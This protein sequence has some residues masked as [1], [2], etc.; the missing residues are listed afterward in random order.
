[1]SRAGDGGVSIDIVL[2]V[3]GADIARAAYY[4]LQS[5]GPVYAGTGSR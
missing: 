3:D 5:I 2:V 4:G 1:M